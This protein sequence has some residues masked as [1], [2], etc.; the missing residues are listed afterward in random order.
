MLP[1][2][3]ES[4][5]LIAVGLLGACVGSFLNVCIYRL[6]REGLSVD[7]PRRS[8][9]PSCGKGVMWYDNLPI[10]SW[11]VLGGRCRFC[12]SSISMRYLVVEAVTALLFVLVAYRYLVRDGSILGEPSWGACGVMSVLVAALVVASCI[13]LDLRILPDE[14]TVRGM[15]VAPLV[16]LLVPEL[17]VRPVDGLLSW[18]LT[19]AHNQLQA[20]QGWPPAFLT[21]D[22][23]AWTCA[24]VA[25]VVGWCAGRWAF[26][27]YW[28]VVHRDEPLQDNVLAGVLGAVSVGAVTY[29]AL[30][31]EAALSPRSYSLLAAL[32]GMLVGSGL[33][34]L[35]GVVG[36]RVFRKPAMGF[37]DVKL[38]GLLGAFTGWAGVLL[39]FFVA[40]LVGSV[41][42]VFVLL[43]YRSRYIPFGP[44]LAAGCLTV[45][46]WPEVLQR[47]FQ[48]YLGMFVVA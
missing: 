35:V 34:F 38:M 1:P 26:S 11:L 21:G 28:G 16:A 29:V 3:L 48:W 30:R 40:C 8:F 41:V 36:E 19:G 15:Q 47:I 14:I 22:V 2:I 31:P 4:L 44:F 25:V 37:G 45:V 10:V 43:V 33:V 7:K 24:A 5:V 17:H 20:I 42:G 23:A 32:A 39:G 12:R 27:T 13:D 6:P 46:L 18:W 9:C